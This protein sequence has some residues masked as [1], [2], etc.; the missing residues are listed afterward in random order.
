[1][2]STAEEEA[3]PFTPMLP[4]PPQFSSPPEKSGA[5]DDLPVGSH[6]PADSSDHWISP[7]SMENAS[8]DID[9]SSGRVIKFRYTIA[10]S[11]YSFEAVLYSSPVVL[12]TGPTSREQIVTERTR[13][14]DAELRRGI[15][16]PESWLETGA[17]EGVAIDAHD[18][19]HALPA[20]LRLDFDVEFI[21]SSARMDSNSDDRQAEAVEKQA[22]DVKRL[23]DYVVAGGNLPQI[24]P[25]KP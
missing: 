22:R 5:W 8:M 3:D 6:P 2:S 13:Q 24:K 12:A 4:P 21:Q 18:M 25:P 7:K 10:C 14:F 1:M 20:D 23:V 11:E 15:K 16:A 17:P 19:I 9:L